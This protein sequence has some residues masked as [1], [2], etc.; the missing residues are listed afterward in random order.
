MQTFNSLHKTFKTDDWIGLLV[1]GTIFSLWFASLFALLTISLSDISWLWVTGFI[2]GRTYLHTG[3]FI[4]A[5]C[6]EI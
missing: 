6:M 4:L 1:F 2:L 5:Q 3:L